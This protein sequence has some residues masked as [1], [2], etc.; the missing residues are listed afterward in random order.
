[1]PD[2]EKTFDQAFAAENINLNS[3][4]S[5]AYSCSFENGIMHFSIDLRSVA[6]IHETK[7][8]IARDI[9][10]CERLL[11]KATGQK[12]KGKRETDLSVILMAGDLRR[13][14]LT[15][16]AIAKKMFPND[17]NEKSEF[18]TPIKS[19]PYARWPSIARSTKS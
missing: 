10:E 16:Q 9:K 8:L 12:R 4:F 14:D 7:K 3:C 17:F 5:S 6:S 19:R 2:P 11:D 13:Q 1:M 15:Y 18:I